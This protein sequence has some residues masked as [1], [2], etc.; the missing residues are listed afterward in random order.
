[1]NQEVLIGSALYAIA[2]ERKRQIEKWGS[3]DSNTLFAWM[4]ILM[5]EVGE[6][7]EAVNE[8]EFM[9]AAHPE[10]GGMEAIQKEAVHVAA[11]AA[12]IIE[13]CIK[14]LTPIYG[15]RY[16]ENGRIINCK[17]CNQPF[18]ATHGSRQYCDKCNTNSTV[19]VRTARARRKE[20]VKD[21]G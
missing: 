19:R 3:Q 8:T 20:Q 14:H 15:D 5:E 4:S 2:E 17:G 16:I 11:V 1:M 6:L 12:S 7:A 21:E 13:V 18:L 9:N 10:R